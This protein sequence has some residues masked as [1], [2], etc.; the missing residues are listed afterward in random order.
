MRR[1]SFTRYGEP[2][3][4]LELLTVDDPPAPAAGE[5]SIRVTKRLLHPGNLCL[6]RGDYPLELPPSGM[7]IGVDGIGVVAAVGDG[8]DESAGVA[9]GTRVAFFPALGAWD[10]YVT[11]LADFVVPIP[12]DI[13]DDVLCQ[14]L[15]NTVA[16]LS[17]LRAAEQA[18]P[19]RAGR[20]MPLLVTAAGSSVARIL[21]TLAHKRGQRVIGVVRSRDGADSL[22]K[23][24][25]ELPVV[26]TADANWQA[27]VREAA[28]GRPLDVIIDPI[29]G[30][31]ATDLIGLLADGGTL[32]FYGGL[33]DEP[34]SI[35]SIWLTF[36]GIALRGVS[37]GRW[38]QD[39]TP[40]Q[41]RE[42]VAEALEIARTVPEQFPVAGE[43]D[44]SDV[45]AAIELVETP[46]RTGGVIL[47]S[48]L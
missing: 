40:E 32:L 18:A 33:A 44:L 47:T 4:V 34:V 14:A 35:P 13:A 3:D 2:A 15:T 30:D 22:A 24:I 45:A 31:M 46:G 27:Q 48:D 8:V 25:P 28:S 38:L 1:F 12:Q 42:D 26:T 16:A 21:T 5:V 37:A 10:E 9:P 11:T 41:R 20:E 17:L 6:I 7:P 23:R 19:G 39:T 36:R 43:F 29:G